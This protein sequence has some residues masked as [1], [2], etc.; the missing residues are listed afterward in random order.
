MC[1]FWPSTMDISFIEG[2]N[3][4]VCFITCC[5][6]S[7][8]IKLAGGEK[9]QRRWRLSLHHSGP[10]KAL[11]SSRPSCCWRWVTAWQHGGAQTL[12][13]IEQAAFHSKGEPFALR[14][15][16]QDELVGRTDSRRCRSPPLTLTAA[17][18]TDR[19]EPRS[20]RTR[21]VFLRNPTWDSCECLGNIE[22]CTCAVGNRARGN[23][24]SLKSLMP[25]TQLSNFFSFFFKGKKKKPRSFEP[26]K[27]KVG[28]NIAYWIFFADGL[29]YINCTYDCVWATVYMREWVC[30]WRRND[31]LTA[32]TVGHIGALQAALHR[33]TFHSSRVAWIDHICQNAKALAKCSGMWDP[34]EKSIS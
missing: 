14:G 25:S 6:S 29:C 34:T 33:C 20:E 15:A 32:G 2:N 3:W 18:K 13:I 1:F 8:A 11:T 10:D 19:T 9:K 24:L 23:S 22:K 27:I 28:N 26:F 16:A 21:A 31:A 17:A 30:P 4:H 12:S 7:L 5:H